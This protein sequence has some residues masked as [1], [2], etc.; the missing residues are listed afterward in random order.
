V[1]AL[2]ERMEGETTTL[3]GFSRYRGTDHDG[4]PLVVD[5][6]L[7]LDGAVLYV[8]GGLV[9]KGGLEGKGALF[10]TGA[11]AVEKGARITSDNELALVAGGDVT[12]TGT[13]RDRS[14]FQGLVYAGGDFRAEQITLL[15]SFVANKQGASTD[16]GS[17]MRLKNAT[18]IQ[19]SGAA[20]MTVDVK[21]P[22][23]PADDPV[24]P[25]IG[26]VATGGTE[27]YNPGA[28]ITRSFSI[29]PQLSA[30]GRRRC[31]DRKTDTFRLPRDFGA[32]DIEFQ[33][34]YTGP[35][36]AQ[37]GGTSYNDG[38]RSGSPQ[39]VTITATCADA[40]A[41]RNRFGI[42]FVMGPAPS[43]GLYH[44]ESVLDRL[45]D[46]ARVDLPP[47]IKAVSQQYDVE[48]SRRPKV[49]GGEQLHIDLNRFVQPES[50]VR[51]LLW[52]EM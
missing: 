42:G 35:P 24:D 28:D 15:G 50:T 49:P 13:G 17:H 30:G 38:T 52:R 16:I 32:R 29:T 37:P 21:V 45:V 40:L 19:T 48:K 31:Y 33:C 23:P 51:V 10:V 6:S 43:T 2:D 25:F 8:D 9:V 34:T 44:V 20:D 5:G 26:Q 22:A 14:A 39:N 3:S 12:L 36:L 11:A 41:I 47:R 7:R 1:S 18:L 46:Q 27:L 4:R